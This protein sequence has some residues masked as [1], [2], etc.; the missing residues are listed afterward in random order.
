MQG[1]RE[2][3][4]GWA[5]CWSL[6]QWAPH[7]L[8][9]HGTWPTD[10]G[11]S[12][13][14]PQAPEEEAGAN[15]DFSADAT[16]DRLRSRAPSWQFPSRTRA[17]RRQAPRTARASQRLAP[18]LDRVAVTAAGPTMKEASSSAS[19]S[20]RVS[21]SLR[22]G[23]GLDLV[24]EILGEGRQ[25]R[26]KAAAEQAAAAQALADADAGRSCL[27]CFDLSFGASMCDAEAKALANQLGLCYGYNKR[28]E[29]PLALAFAGLEQASLPGIDD[30]R[31]SVCEA[32]H[33]WG[34]DR[35]HVRREVPPPWLAFPLERQ[36]YLTAD[37]PTVLTD[38]EPGMVYIM[39]GLVD[40]TPK[41]GVALAAAEAHRVATA[42]LPLD[43]FVTIHKASEKGTLTCLACFQIL[44]GYERTRDWGRAVREAPAMHCAP[45]R[46]YV[47]WKGGLDAALKMEQRP[48][49]IA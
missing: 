33:G 7:T 13:R 46:K 24:I 22:P 20:L 37:A 15:R 2:L 11:G 48:A 36:V 4:L 14:E 30:G 28:L 12:L 45:L 1:S 21:L 38:L 3:Q 19:D 34:W 49:R 29:R 8:I 43:E 25:P 18:S 27:L 39:G 44:A 26:R 41:P 5:A 31:L 47:V 42:R 9:R 10:C 17:R 23:N 6:L 32:L 16:V 40:H 35:W